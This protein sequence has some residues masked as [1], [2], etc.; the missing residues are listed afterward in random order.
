MVANDKCWQHQLFFSSAV[1]PIHY[2][3]AHAWFIISSLRT[4]VPSN[5]EAFF[6]LE[7]LPDDSLE[8]AR[9][10]SGQWSSDGI[11]GELGEVVK[12][13]RL[14]ISSSKLKNPGCCLMSHLPFYFPL[15][16]HHFIS[17]S[18]CQM[19]ADDKCWLHQSFFSGAVIPIRYISAH[20]WFIASLWSA[21][22]STNEA[23][24]DL[25]SAVTSGHSLCLWWIPPQCY[26]HHEHSPSECFDSHPM[27]IKTNGEERF[28]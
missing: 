3:T 25:G 20:A 6:D 17:S 1:T 11:D 14:L 22:V 7:S 10:W 27:N 24:I 9:S 28:H 15:R 5:H 12:W 19:V 23:L 2:L 16:H 26:L 4:M 18:D 13:G 21:V 8:T